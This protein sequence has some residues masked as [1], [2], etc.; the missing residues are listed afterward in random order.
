M[1]IAKKRMIDIVCD[2]ILK[3]H[4]LKRIVSYSQPQCIE[5]DREARAPV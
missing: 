2:L 3:Y 4:S 5:L 1:M